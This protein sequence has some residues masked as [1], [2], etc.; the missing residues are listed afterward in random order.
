MKHFFLWLTL[1]A[2][3]ADSK[4]TP[5]TEP[6]AI[7]RRLPPPGIEIPASDRTILLDVA[8]GVERLSTDIDVAIY[9]DAVR[10][11]LR[12]GEFY[13][14]RDVGRAQELLTHATNRAQELKSG[15]LDWNSKRGTLVRGY[16]SQL[17]DSIQPYGLVIPE[18]LDL[19]KPVPLYV[20]LH[21]RGDKLT[22]LAFIREREAKPGE[23]HPDDA[24]VLHPYGR[25]CNG[26]KFAGEVDVLESIDAVSK[27]YE[28]DPDRIVLVG[29]SMGGAGA[30]HLGAHYA[31]RWC[32]VSP[33]A[34]FAE[35]ARYQKLKPEKFP[36]WYEQRLWGLYDVPDY[37][38]NFFNIPLIAYSGELDGQ[39][40]SAKVMAEAYEKEGHHLTHLIG[41]GVG[42]KYEPKTLVE[43]QKQLA[44]LAHKGRPKYPK[45][46]TL[47]TQTLRY[48]RYGPVRML[49]LGEHW[50]DARVDA[51]FDQGEVKTR[52]VTGLEI[53]FA[54]ASGR[55]AP[56]S[57]KLDGQSLKLSA[58]S[59]AT[60]EREKD[61]WRLAERFPS[62]PLLRKIHGLQGPIDDAFME[63]FLVVTPSGSVDSWTQFELDHFQDRWR[64]LFRGEPRMKA[65]ADV[66]A[67]DMRRYHLI[68]WGDPRSNQILS[69]AAAKLPFGWT[70]QEITVGERTFDAKTHLL[71]AIYPNPL[72]PSRYLVINSG[73]TYREGHDASNSLQTPKLPDWAVIDTTMKPDALAA[74]RVVAADFFDEHWQLKPARQAP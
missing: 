7:P 53:D 9:T 13:D 43:L 37:T 27:A 61:E 52:N 58:T 42:H 14:K 40:Q 56:S 41:P 5:G 51:D 36:P 16:R 54:K 1:V 30:W 39:I 32:A 4:V 68:V 17:D 28:I 20:W 66:T 22:E 74:G 46:V 26:F 35:T 55:R 19:S 59:P 72:E 11:A 70:E 23:F 29:F 50:S 31:E 10:K 3:L 8:R 18:K 21:G 25:F 45:Q 15:T 71:L 64:R 49:G 47:E 33:G 6:V 63:P 65:D 67:E 69:Q 60:F 73:P 12:Q 48:D 24:I 62:S 34:G 57:I 38:L 44:E 2:V